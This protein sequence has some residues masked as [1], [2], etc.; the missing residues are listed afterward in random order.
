MTA[1]PQQAGLDLDFNEDQAA[2]AAAVDRF[3]MQRGVA[4]IARETNAPFPRQLWRELAEV[5]VFYP[6]APGQHAGGA[7]ALCAIAETL[8]RHVFP[9]PLA[10]TCIALQVLD[11][12][13]AAGLMEGTALVSLSSADSTLLPFGTEADIF[14]LAQDDRLSLAHPPEQVAAVATLGGETWGRALLKVDQVLPNARRGLLV[15]NIVTSAYLV[16]A[17]WQLLRD[18]S[19]HAAT[20]KQF[21]KTLGEFQAVTH[22]L[23]DCAIGLTGAQT[24]AR[25]AACSFDDGDTGEAEGLAAG[26]LLAARRASLDTAFACHQV[27]AGIGVT[28]E[29]PAFHF[30]RRIRQLASSPPAGTREQERLL[31]DAGLGT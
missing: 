2:I 1:G 7:L 30:T 23:A 24:L 13:T 16:G 6:A 12:D 26:A 4:D 25:A 14:L 15:G 9:G 10:A 3:C 21:G 27:F 29:G 8:G 22:P 17:A 31:A 18:A 5:G 11:E 28:L 20:R 19:E